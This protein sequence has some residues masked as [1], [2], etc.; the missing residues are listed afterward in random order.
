MRAVRYTALAAAVLAYGLIVLGG[1]VRAT[2]SG[3][4]CPDWP[5]CYGHFALTPAEFEALGDVGYTYF[6]TML[7]W[8]HRFVAGVLLGPLLLGLALLAY[9]KRRADP[10]GL[11]LAL[12]IL[13]LLVV[14]GSLGGVT[15]LDANSPWSVALHLGNALV[16]LSLLWLAFLRQGAQ[17]EAGL[18]RAYAGLAALTWF[19]AI[20]AMVT[21][22]MTAKSGASL[23]C[24]T[25][26]ECNGAWLPPLGDWDVRIHFLHRTLAGL[27]GFLVLALAMTARGEA[28]QP[29]RPLAAAA[30][31]LVVLQVSLGA[32]VILF[33]VPTWSQVA[34]QAVGVVLLSTLA[35]L[36]WQAGRA[37]RPT[38]ETREVIDDVRL[39]HA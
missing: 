27:T 20:G 24:S 22:A 10:G 38:P 37:A 11:K 35:C 1:W 31:A 26:P 17:P 4:S 30:L 39:R 36:M 19:V 25:W 33:E 7:E 16:L 3:L 34:H 12:G 8:V 29:V 23:A 32:A 18:S 15:V 28:A 9:L 6:Q 2:N 21:A 14:Q 13:A 5:T